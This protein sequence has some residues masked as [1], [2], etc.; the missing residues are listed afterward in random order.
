M[1]HMMHQQKMPPVKIINVNS[2]QLRSLYYITYEAKI[3]FILSLIMHHHEKRCLECFQFQ[4]DYHAS[5]DLQLDFVP[6]LTQEECMDTSEE[7]DLK[8]TRGNGKS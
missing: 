1:S 4:V 7:G 2:L 6:C 3:N 8:L 5:S